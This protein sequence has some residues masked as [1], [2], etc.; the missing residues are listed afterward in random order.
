MK[1]AQEKQK[2][3]MQSSI[4]NN[5]KAAKRL[6]DD[7]K[8]KQATS[9]KKKLGDRMGMEVSAKGTRF[10]LNRD[11]VGWHESHRDAI[12]VPEFDP[13]PRM[14]VP[15]SPP[16]L[17]TAGP[18]LSFEGSSKT[19]DPELEN[20]MSFSRDR[21]SSDQGQGD[22]TSIDLDGSRTGTLA[23][24]VASVFNGNG[25]GQH[26]KH[27]LPFK[28]PSDHESS[29]RTSDTIEEGLK[30]L[31]RSNIGSF[32][33]PR[34]HLDG[35]RNKTL[36]QK[37]ADVFDEIG[38]RQ[39]HQ[40]HYLDF[41]GYEASD[42]VEQSF[43][44]TTPSTVP[45]PQV[46]EA[47][48]K[49]QS[50]RIKISR[51][52]LKAAQPDIF[53]PASNNVYSA[54]RMR[55]SELR[56][57]LADDSAAANHFSKFSGLASA[58]STVG[59]TLRQSLAATDVVAKPKADAIPN[60]HYCE[61][62]SPAGAFKDR[63]GQAQA[64][65]SLKDPVGSHQGNPS[66]TVVSNS[67]QHVDVD[68]DAASQSTK[69]LQ[70]SEDEPLNAVWRRFAALEAQMP[71]TPMLAPKEAGCDAGTLPK[72]TP[73][74]SPTR[75]VTND[76]RSLFKPVPQD[77]HDVTSVALSL[78]DEWPEYDSARQID[79]KAKIAEIKRRPSRKAM[80]GRPA[81][82]SRRGSHEASQTGHWMPQGGN[83][84]TENLRGKH[85]LSVRI[86][87]QSIDP[88]PVEPNV[89]YYDTLEGF[90]GLPQHPVPG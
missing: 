30:P 35:P 8:L 5:V 46:T 73:W 29:E 38:K 48:S 47:G 14:E 24:T 10:K 28:N 61:E 42:P 53:K 57:L 51:E 34:N 58:S 69:A 90:F 20:A 85:A 55:R 67:P 12:E 16:D 75:G 31:N 1:D 33:D 87:A 86:V 37:V 76:E 79:R 65:E 11:L 72:T 22:D 32:L 4:D 13:P 71:S 15:P 62:A 17:R 59:P 74:R 40:K 70:D 60:D 89:V 26:Q 27:Y 9:R 84:S 45:T 54:Q 25:K 6:G 88:F 80:F 36:A 3:H 83:L 7:K 19:R 50:K 64:A 63:S 43:T 77:E 41:E 39:Q 78:F 18:L 21:G 68:E 81:L 56:N 49:T 44:Q 23:R 52:L 66:L 2:K 82:Y